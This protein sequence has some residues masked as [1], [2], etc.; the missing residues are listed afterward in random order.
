MPEYGVKSEQSLL[1]LTG[2]AFR[3]TVRRWPLYAIATLAAF[4]FQATLVLVLRIPHGTELSSAIALPL[5]VTLAYAFVS[6]DDREEPQPD[7]LTWERFLERAWAVIVIDFLCGEVLTA[8][9]VYSFANDAL[10]VVVGVAAFGLSVLVIFADASATVDD[11]VNVWTVIPR[12][13]LRSAAVALTPRVLVRALALFSLELLI[14][15]AQNTL[16]F[17]LGGAPEPQRSFWASVP[18]LTLTA[19]PLSALVVLVY[20]DAKRA[21]VHE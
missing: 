7:A 19:V 16:Y 15:A 8:G 18:L 5:L 4:A 21:L 6:A 17:G 1:A 10:Q 3:L 20:R 13:F 11:D 9:W 14:V 12:A 2:L